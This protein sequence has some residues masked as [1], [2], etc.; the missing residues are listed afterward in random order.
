MA[1]RCMESWARVCPDYRV[2]E[3][4]EDSFD[5]SAFPYALKAYNSR[6][7][8]FVSDV[9]RLTALNTYGGFYLDTDVELIRSLDPFL[10][11]RCVLGFEEKN[12][13]ATSLMGSE[14]DHELMARFLGQYSEARFV[15]SDNRMDFTTNVRRLT[16]LLGDY[17]LRPDGSYQELRAGI[18]VYPQEYFSPFDYI[19]GRM[20]VTSNTHCIHHFD[21][22][23]VPWYRKLGRQ[24][25]RVGTGVCSR[26]V[27]RT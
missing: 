12:Y 17:G 3:W 6:K 7:Y 11:Q 19:N 26:L 2:M 4:N 15:R 24:V 27:S 22:S 18:V 9:A 10:Q 14:P 5:I 1:I 8:A 23:W 25:R 20:K 16:S 21:V 13:I